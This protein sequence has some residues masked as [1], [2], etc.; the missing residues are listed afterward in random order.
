M[1]LSLFTST[2]SVNYTKCNNSSNS[3]T[4]CQFIQ[5]SQCSNETQLCECQL[6]FTPD[7]EG[8]MCRKGELGDP[9]TSQ[10]ACSVFIG[11]STCDPMIKQCVC[12]PGFKTVTTTTYNSTTNSSTDIVECIKRQLGEECTS[13]TDCSTA[14][15]NSACTEQDANQ[16]TSQTVNVCGCVQGYEPTT[17]NTSCDCLFTYE[18]QCLPVK[19]NSTSCRSTNDSVCA[20][21]VANSECSSNGVCTCKN[22]FASVNGGSVCMDRVLESSCDTNSDCS[23]KLNNTGCFNGI[24]EC[25]SG[26]V[27]DDDHTSCIAN[28]Y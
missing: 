5:N 6:G 14:V 24:C 3:N 11:N 23:D 2:D 9:C 19:I 27:S 4:D 12:L 15:P 7:R 25:I 1:L 28:E 18:D 20:T 22:G 8:T 10:E 26:F 13:D 17:S 16:H 21:F